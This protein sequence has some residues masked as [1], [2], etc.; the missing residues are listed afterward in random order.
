MTFG[1]GKKE[2]LQQ[3]NSVLFCAENENV[4]TMAKGKL[5]VPQKIAWVF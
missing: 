5:M 2:T 4:Q 3:N 1:A